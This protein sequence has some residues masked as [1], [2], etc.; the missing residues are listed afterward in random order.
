[1]SQCLWINAL[2]LSALASKLIDFFMEDSAVNQNLCFFLP[3]KSSPI[4]ELLR[5]SSVVWKSSRVFQRDPWHW[6]LRLHYLPRRAWEKVCHHFIK[7]KLRSIGCDIF[8][9]TR[10]TQSWDICFFLDFKCS[11]LFIA[12]CVLQSSSVPPF[13]EYVTWLCGQDEWNDRIA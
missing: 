2:G 9:Q 3:W 5:C 6:S 13:R 4:G 10:L 12:N 11:L 7:V 1:M 8:S